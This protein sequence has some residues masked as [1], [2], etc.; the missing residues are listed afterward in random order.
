MISKTADRL[1]G[2]RYQIEGGTERGIEEVGAPEG[3]D[4]CQ[5]SLFNTP[6]RK[7]FLKTPM[8]EDTRGSS[9]RKDCSFHPDI[10]IRLIQN[11]QNKLYTSEITI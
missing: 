3:T 4:H 10:S 11:N 9:G 6:V 7:K 1:T 8:T 2:T 5:K